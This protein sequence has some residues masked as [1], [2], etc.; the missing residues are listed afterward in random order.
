MSTRFY[1]RDVAA[2]NGKTFRDL[3]LRETKLYP[4]LADFLP[5]NLGCDRRGAVLGMR[6]GVRHRRDLGTMSRCIIVELKRFVSAAG[7]LEQPRRDRV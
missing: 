6:P 3:N 1:R 7:H 5:D 4:R 2:G